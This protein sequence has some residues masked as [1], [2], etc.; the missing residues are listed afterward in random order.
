MNV[1]AAPLGDTPQPNP[2]QKLSADT[3]SI[4]LRGNNRFISQ[5]RSAL[6]LLAQC[7]EQAFLMVDENIDVIMEY[8]RSGMEVQSNTFLASNTTAYAPGYSREAQVFW[9]AGT[10]VHDA[11]HNLQDAQGIN[12]D[13]GNLTI[14]QREALELAAIAVQVSTLERCLPFLKNS[15]QK[16]GEKMLSYLKSM[17]DGNTTCNYCTVGW[18]DRS[19]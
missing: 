5:T 6:N 4:E 13:W 9:Y 7:D 16:E 17:R 15:T 10:M 19:W 8:N 14:E 18:E 3:A 2:K 12:T 1:K 11:Y